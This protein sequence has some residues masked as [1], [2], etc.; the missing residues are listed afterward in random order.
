M[1]VKDRDMRVQTWKD[2]MEMC[3]EVEKGTRFKPRDPSSPSSLA[4]SVVP[5]ND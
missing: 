4:L 5:V 1:L 2:V 3:V